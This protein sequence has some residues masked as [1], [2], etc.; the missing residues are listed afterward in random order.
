MTEWMNTWMDGGIGGFWRTCMDGWADG[1]KGNRGRGTS[2]GREIRSH[3][4]HLLVSIVLL[5]RRRL[6]GEMFHYRSNGR[7]LGS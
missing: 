6:E 1:S 2:A 4:G 7:D 5:K 3:S